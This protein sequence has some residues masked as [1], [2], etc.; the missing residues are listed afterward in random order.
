[1]SENGRHSDGSLCIGF[2]V[3][4]KCT[5]EQIAA[6]T[7]KLAKAEEELAKAR[8]RIDQLSAACV[9][10][11]IEE[12]LMKK[13]IGLENALIEK[14]KKA[15]SR[16]GRITEPAKLLVEELVDF[17]SWESRPDI[18]A[19]FNRLKQALKTDCKHPGISIDKECP[20][21]GSWTGSVVSEGK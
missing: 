13:T 4:E 19:A 9:L 5:D 11:D 8:Q 2:E 10:G 16:L 14:L 6:L 21:C 12:S 3:C 15:E 20:M 17:N 7:A 1:M 18:G